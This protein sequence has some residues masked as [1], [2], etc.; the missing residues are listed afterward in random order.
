MGSEE[1]LLHTTQVD[2]QMDSSYEEDARLSPI[3]SKKRKGRERLNNP[4]RDHKG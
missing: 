3:K 1:E 2:E 4:T